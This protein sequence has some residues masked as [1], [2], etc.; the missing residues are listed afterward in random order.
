VTSVDKLNIALGVVGIAVTLTAAID[1]TLWPRIA[2]GSSKARETITPIAAHQLY[3][4]RRGDTLIGLAAR[5]ANAACWIAIYRSNPG[6]GPNP[7]RLLPGTVLTIP[8]PL[9]CSDEDKRKARKLLEG[10][11]TAGAIKLSPE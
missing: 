3:I 7:S 1:P 2:P 11:A 10:D 4:I 6:I 8:T 5:R 9:T